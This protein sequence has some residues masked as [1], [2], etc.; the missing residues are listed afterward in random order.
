MRQVKQHRYLQIPQL[1]FDM[2]TY[3]H[4]PYLT[5]YQSILLMD[6]LYMLAPV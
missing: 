5:Q 3:T 4:N 2:P 6:L 1:I